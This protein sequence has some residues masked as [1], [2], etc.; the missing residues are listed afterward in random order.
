MDQSKYDEGK[1]NVLDP[2]NEKVL[3]VVKG[4][5]V[6]YFSPQK[7]GIVGN[8][9]LETKFASQT[10]EKT[11]EPSNIKSEEGES[12]LLQRHKTIVELFDGMSCSLRLLGMR[13]RPPTFHNI[14]RQVE[15]LTRRKFSYRHLAQL[16]YLFHE[17]IQID[18]ILVHDKKTLCMKP[19]MKI[20][21]LF[22]VVEGHS[23]Q[24]D[25]IALHQLFTSRLINY[26]TAHPE[27]CDIPEAML[28]DPFNQRKEAAFVDKVGDIPDVISP[29]LLSQ[30]SQT[31]AP[32]Q[33]LANASIEDLP[34][35]DNSEFLSKSSH[36]PPSFCR[37]FS[38]KV[39]AV[40]KTQLLASPSPLS[41]AVSCN[42]ENEDSETAKT[43]EF[44]D[45]SSKSNCGPACE[46]VKESPD[47]ISKFTSGDPLS[48]QSI[49]SELSVN[50]NIC[51]SPLGKLVSSANNLMVETPAQSIPK[52]GI[53]STDD[54]HKSIPSQKQPSSSKAAKRSLNFSFL[55][56]DKSDCCECLSDN[57]SQDVDHS[58]ALLPEVEEG[59]GCDTEERRMSRSDL[60]H[61]QISNYLPGLVSLIHHIF[62]SI[63]YS[64]ITK[65]EL[66]HKIII[67][68]FDFDE[69]RQVEE[70]I[71]ILEKQ[72]P[73]WIC[74]KPVPSGDALYSIKKMVDLKSVQ[75]RVASI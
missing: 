23:E 26:F 74:R 67:N 32:G 34:T 39:V 68:S 6:L 65:E 3:P 27:A 64:A 33:S 37:H 29:E 54:K 31:I 9:S 55:E 1:Q 63:N 43:R 69:R 53:A 36:M 5:N 57:M 45:V 10:P 75:S 24:S 4:L 17:A 22:D 38:E 49:H 8:Q 51:A 71:E 20:M 66:V 16:K 62:C 25:F 58:S 73:D 21:L 14:C 59:L 18:K 19:D 46:Q 12:E 11:S 35:T 44:P 70:Q 2:K 61:Q 28:P 48:I 41:S 30:L 50:T 60:I 42:V 52:R 47:T 72:V 15:V 7:P 40:D 56:S 13:K